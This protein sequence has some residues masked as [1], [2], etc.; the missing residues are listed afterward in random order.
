MQSVSDDVSMP[1]N[2]T[3]ANATTMDAVF[4]QIQLAQVHFSVFDSLSSAHNAG[5]S[6]KSIADDESVQNVPSDVT[7]ETIYKP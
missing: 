2:V 5:F 6:L 3:N 1:N 4:P 7:N